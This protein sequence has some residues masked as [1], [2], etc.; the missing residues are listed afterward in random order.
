MKTHPTRRL[1]IAGF[2]NQYTS[3]HSRRAH[4]TWLEGWFE[5]HAPA[6]VPNPLSSGAIREGVEAV[7]RMA[8]RLREDGSPPGGSEER[9]AEA[10]AQVQ[11]L[12]ALVEARRDE[13][14]KHAEPREVEFLRRTLLN[15]LAH[16][17]GMR[18]VNRADVH[19]TPMPI[20]QARDER[21][22]S[23]LAFLANEYYPGKK[24][25][26]WAASSHLLKNPEVCES[27]YGRNRALGEDHF[28]PMGHY[29]AA[30]L[31]ADYFTI[32]FTAHTGQIGRP[33]SVPTAI[34]PSEPGD[35]ETL[36]AEAGLSLAIVP[37]KPPK[38]DAGAAWLRNPQ[39][40]RP[41]GYGRERAVWGQCFDAVMFTREMTPSTK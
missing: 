34:P 39:V 8:S 38:D 18:G 2:D 33:W 16:D 3:T 26:A 22:G 11:A 10:R 21:M 37:L 28:K 36:M 6:D 13:L 5:K 14:A 12:M 32:T 4:A 1:I 23:N 25:I 20:L 7:R 30:E 17:L 9:P 41:M 24:I 15:L 27:L 19:A 40:M 35:L 29:A 31:G